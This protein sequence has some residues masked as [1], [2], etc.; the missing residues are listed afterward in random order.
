M[1]GMSCDITWY[2]VNFILSNLKSRSSVFLTISPEAV[3]KSAAVAL[4]KGSIVACVLEK[5]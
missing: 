5:Y 1:Y 2:T 3:G 4:Q